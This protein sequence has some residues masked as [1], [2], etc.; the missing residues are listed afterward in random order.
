MAL[1]IHHL[2][3]NPA[4]YH[5]LYKTGI[6]HCICIGCLKKI[7]SLKKK[8][9]ILPGPVQCT[10]QSKEKKKEKDCCD[11]LQKKKVF[12]SLMLYISVEECAQFNYK[13]KEKLRNLFTFLPLHNP[14][15]EQPSNSNESNSSQ[16]ARACQQRKLMGRQGF[17]FDVGKTP[18]KTGLY[19]GTWCQTRRESACLTC[20]FLDNIHLL[21][22]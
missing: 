22:A 9:A 17:S 18:V 20:G 11:N 8:N 21:L 6:F 12:L 5:L 1:D 19:M 13:D 2:A 7:R 4:R 16:T 3:G 15:H 14:V 10:L